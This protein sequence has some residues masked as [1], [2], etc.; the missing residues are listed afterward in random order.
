MYYI[1]A[2]ELLNQKRVGRLLIP[3]RYTYLSMTSLI[4][5]INLSQDKFHIFFRTNAFTSG[6][7]LKLRLDDSIICVYVHPT[8]FWYTQQIN[9]PISNSCYHETFFVHLFYIIHFKPPKESGR[10]TFSVIIKPCLF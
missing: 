10:N 9:A 5:R 4:L 6:N 1:N 7:S 8:F 2:Y 3:R